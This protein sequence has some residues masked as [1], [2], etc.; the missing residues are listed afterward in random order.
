[1]WDWLQPDAAPAAPTT[2]ADAPEL[3]ALLAAIREAPDD[4]VPQL[5]LADWLDEHGDAFARR[6]SELHR[7]QAA[8]ASTSADDEDRPEFARRI[9]FLRAPH[10]PD[11]LKEREQPPEMDGPVPTP[12]HCSGWSIA[13]GRWTAYLSPAEIL[14]PELLDRLAALPSTWVDTVQLTTATTEQVQELAHSP[15]VAEPRRLRIAVPH[16]AGHGAAAI[17]A[18]A[19]HAPLPRLRELQLR[20]AALAGTALE[21]LVVSPL[22]TALTS[23]DLG[24]SLLGNS[25][26][27]TLSA[28]LFPGPL[29][30]LILPGNDI[31]PNGL[32]ELLRAPVLATL[33][34]LVL[35]R[36]LLGNRGASVL[37][38]GPPLPL[39]R[40]RLAR[41]HV[42]SR[43]AKDL[44][45]S[46]R[47]SGLELLDLRG[48]PI[49]PAGRHALRERFGRRVL[50]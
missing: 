23:L 50:V 44:A 4:A 18:L 9:E 1:M 34:R 28:A 31:G 19:A 10:L 36:N 7:L 15:I 41:C 38:D 42:S 49:G 6:C 17:E 2:P 24:N 29:Q 48:N 21:R 40:L 45:Q 13:L 33:A 26:A 22:L 11:W 14:A 20:S 32:A 35:N 30:A 39:R 37:A 27:R 3:R 43:G 8:L 47:L 16:D 25:G 12:D 5:L 46:E